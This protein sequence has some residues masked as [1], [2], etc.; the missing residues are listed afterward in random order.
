MAFDL[1]PVL[2]GRHLTLRPLIEG[3]VEALCAVASDPLVWEQHPVTDRY[4][5][6][7][8]TSFFA[9]ALACGGTLIVLDAT[10][11]VIGSRGSTG[12]RISAARSRLAG[13]S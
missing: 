1:Q 13:P 3:D 2:R 8:F 5:R 11:E 7:V 6:G 10:G 9:D 12:T 4:R